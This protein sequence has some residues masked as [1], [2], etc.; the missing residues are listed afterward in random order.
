MRAM[1]LERRLAPGKYRLQVADY[2]MIAAAG[3]F[4]DERTELIEGDVL[5]M[6]PQYRPHGYAKTEFYNQLHDGLKAIDSPLRVMSELSVDLSDVSMPMPDLCLTS[7]PNGPGAIP[8]T[9][10]A[11]V[12]E[13]AS[14]TLSD[15]LGIKHRLY[16]A[17]SVPEYWVADVDGR[18]LH[19]FWRPVGDAYI[20]Q[21]QL[22]FGECIAA[23]SVVGLMV[24]TDSL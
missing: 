21:R 8:L 17:A 9:S 24:S 18:V 20:E 6:G 15:N 23:E 4:G 11:L 3:A 1:T 16:A 12:V 10:V 19:Q 14:T 13:I 7:E 5:V 2:E 22:A